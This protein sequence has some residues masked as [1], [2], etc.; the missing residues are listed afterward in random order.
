MSTLFQKTTTKWAFNLYSIWLF[1]FSDLKT[2]V[3]PS[4]A[5]GLFN[6]TAA[7]L[8]PTTTLPPP[9]QI[10][11]RT[12]LVLLWVWINLLPF[13]INNQRQPAAIQE[14]AL[15]KPWRPMPSRRL[16][17]TAAKTLM[18][19]FY[20]LAILTSLALGNLAQCLALIGLG[21]WY[22]DLHGADAS[23]L[24]R[25][26]INAGGFIS[27]ASGAMQVAIGG[28]DSALQLLGWWSA[29][30]ACIV[31]STVQTQ[32]M[33]DQRG[34]AA[35]NRKTVPLVMG[36]APARW[37]IAVPMVVW[38]VMTPWLWKSSK[39]GYVAPVVLGLTVAVRTLWERS[40]R[41][42]RNTFRI[43]NL[44]MVSVYL[45]PLIKA[46]EG[47]LVEGWLRNV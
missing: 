30:I 2:I 26:L 11:H 9:S 19:V 10:L 5:F 21:Y 40:E 25:N 29:V 14:D 37:T 22:N 8:N 23:C 32:D 33:Y 1:T 13:A 35:R 16:S 41:G 12:P 15:N 7:S 20:P 3:L 34:D 45:L 4:T 42:D 44:W 38:C 28:R 31:F 18:L 46:S 24:V 27:F 43:W 47:F 36:D 17:P 39:V 6:A